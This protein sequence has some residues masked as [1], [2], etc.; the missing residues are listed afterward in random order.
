MVSY[1]PPPRVGFATPR[2]VGSVVYVSVDGF[3]A[4][5]CAFTAKDGSLRWWTPTDAR[6]AAMPFMDW[7][8]PLV[9]DGIAYIVDGPT[10]DVVRRIFTWADEGNSMRWIARRL[11][12]ENILTP[13]QAAT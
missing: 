9:K 6:V 7:A 5:T 8:V 1:P 4:Y 3:G 10:A 11:I 13:S 12:D 2:V